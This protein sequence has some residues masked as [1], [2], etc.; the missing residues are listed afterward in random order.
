MRRAQAAA[1][2]SVVTDETNG[3]SILDKRIFAGDFL[4]DGHEDLLFSQQLEEMAELNPLPLNQL[5]DGQWGGNLAGQIT[6]PIG[7]L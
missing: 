1:A 4:V 7:C 6:L 5:P 3:V 2:H